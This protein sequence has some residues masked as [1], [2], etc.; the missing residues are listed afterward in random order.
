MKSSADRIDAEPEDVAEHVCE[1]YVGLSVRID[2]PFSQ[3]KSSQ[4]M[5][6]AY[7]FL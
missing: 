4:H 3:G 5:G 1:E 2:E 7:T 6:I